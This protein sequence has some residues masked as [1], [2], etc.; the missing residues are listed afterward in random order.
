MLHIYVYLLLLLAGG[1]RVLVEFAPRFLLNENFTVIL[2]VSLAGMGL[3]LVLALAFV[4]ILALGLAFAAVPD[5]LLDTL[6]PALPLLA[7]AAVAAL[8]PWPLPSVL[9][10]NF[11]FF[12]GSV[13]GAFGVFGD[14][15]LGVFGVAE[16]TLAVRTF[17][18]GAFCEKRMV[19]RS[20]VR[21]CSSQ[22]ERTSFLERS[23]LPRGLEK[24][25]GK[26]YRNMCLRKKIER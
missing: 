8:R 22:C 17:P 5:P 11:L 9:A 23:F 10:P 6:V 18:P 19:S 16:V 3:G 2:L 25:K 4:L 20:K 15:P 14:A 13:L 1:P 7:A 24:L 26:L 21:L 12:A